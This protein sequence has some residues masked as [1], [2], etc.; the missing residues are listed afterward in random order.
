MPVIE[1][2]S[3]PE[4]ELNENDMIPL[5]AYGV[6]VETGEVI[7]KEGLIPD[8]MGVIKHLGEILHRIICNTVIKYIISAFST[9]KKC[10][11]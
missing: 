11:K 1:A 3:C 10:G 2:P 6:D 4:S 5:D 7:G 9:S 8:D